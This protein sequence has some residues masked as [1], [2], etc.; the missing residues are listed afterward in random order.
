M[1]EL[2][3]STAA[4]RVKLGDQISLYLAPHYL[5]PEAR[6]MPPDNPSPSASCHT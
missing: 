6:A 4:P 5:G 2:R 3:I 1:H